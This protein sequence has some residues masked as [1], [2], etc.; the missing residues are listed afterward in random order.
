MITNKLKKASLKSTFQREKIL[1]YIISRKEH[2]TADMI[3][4]YM[5]TLSP[6]ISKTTVY[7]TVKSLTK[8][9]LIKSVKFLGQD[10]IRYDGTVDTHHHFVCEKC[11][12][13]YDIEVLCQNFNKKEING[14]KINNVYAYFTGICKE[15]KK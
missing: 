13:I 10:E 6:C 15:C 8:T 12:K 1:E 2:P 4:R 9:N 14:H 5:L 7:N 3:Y 11:G